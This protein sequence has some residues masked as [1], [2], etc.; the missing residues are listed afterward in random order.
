LYFL[1]TAVDT[2]A[3]RLLTW[4]WYNNAIR[5]AAVGVIPAALA[6]AAALLAVPRLLGRRFGSPLVELAAA[7]LLVGLVVVPSEAWKDRDVAFMKPYFHP[8][9]ARSWASP[10]ELTALHRLARYI[11]PGAVT[12]ADPWRGGTYLYVVIGRKLDQVGTEPAV[13]RIARE[14]HIEYALTGGVPFLWGRTQ[15]ERGYPGFENLARSPAWRQVAKEGPY[16]LYRRVAC[17]E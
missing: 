3:L 2:E 13:C 4:P 15:S 10:E 9:V 16:T 5:I 12:A 1:N 17:A 6:V 7:A 11:P 8:G 14:N